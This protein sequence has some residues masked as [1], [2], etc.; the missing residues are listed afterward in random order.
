PGNAPGLEVTDETTKSGPLPTT[1]RLPAFALLSSNSSVIEL[2][3]SAMAPTHQ[4]PPDGA[5]T[6]AVF[7]AHSPGWRNASG[8]KLQA[9]MSVGLMT[10]SVEK[11]RSTGE[12]PGAVPWLQY[13]ALIVTWAPG[14]ALGA[15]LTEEMTKSGPLP[16]ATRLPAFA[17]L[18][19]KSSCV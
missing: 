2:N 6:E 15:V 19:S 8:G 13:V 18:S 4:V 11:K 1:S 10:A 12:L 16:T 5:P 9:N 7:V 17:L 3:E 14:E